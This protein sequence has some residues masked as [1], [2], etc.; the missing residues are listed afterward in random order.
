MARASAGGRAA[1]GAR[2]RDAP[3][4]GGRRRASRV[5]R[6]PGPGRREP[7]RAPLR[8]ART[9]RHARRFVP[10]VA[11]RAAGGFL[12]AR[13]FRAEKQ[14]GGVEKRVRAS[15]Q[16]QVPVRLGVLRARRPA[17]RRG[18]PGVETRRGPVAGG[19]GGQARERRE[20]RRRR[21]RKRARRHIVGRRRRRS[22]VTRR[23][24]TRGRG[25]RR[26]HALRVRVRRVWRLRG[27]AAFERRERADDAFF[28]RA[29]NFFRRETER[30]G[31]SSRVPVPRR[32]GVRE[33]ARGS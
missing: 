32:E 5:R 11:R 25:V 3:E 20:R 31:A 1:V 14:R 30:R 22:R 26:R 18:G 10:R 23:N 29:G 24:A 2:R 8:R 6:L 4:T 16:A 33:G 17:A 13:L 7:V 28:G 21:F 9:R 12:R 27:G 19:G 15:V